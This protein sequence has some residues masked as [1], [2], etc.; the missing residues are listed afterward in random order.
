MAPEVI[1]LERATYASDIWSLACVCVELLTG[2]PPYSDLLAMTAMF[3]IVEDDM[4]PLPENCS[5]ELVDFLQLCFAKEP[6][7]RPT[8]EMLF[9][10][11]WLRKHWQAHKNTLRPQDSI[12]F[13]RRISSEYTR[14]PAF[15]REASVASDVPDLDRSISSPGNSSLLSDEPMSPHMRPI[16][17]LVFDADMASTGPSPSL[18]DADAIVSDGLLF[19]KA[20]EPRQMAFSMPDAF[21]S[22]YCAIDMHALTNIS[23]PFPRDVGLA[24]QEPTIG[25]A[26]HSFVRTVFGR[27]EH[28]LY[29]IVVDFLMRA[30]SHCM[31][32]VWRRSPEVCNPL[33]GVRTLL[34]PFL[35]GIRPTTVRGPPWL[36][37]NGA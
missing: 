28:F 5:P 12:P 33:R 23:Q 29:F 22:P 26:V 10:H 25:G 1:K 2:K 15:A 6:E 17:P 3:K 36:I 14:R 19:A 31:P 16:D 30:L 21:V 18:T 13:I 32:G 34:P 4:P 9:E 35:P 7:D 24:A 8:A 27:R 11:A 37:L 20:E